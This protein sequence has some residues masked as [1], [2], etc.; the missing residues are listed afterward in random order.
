MSHSI[1]EQLFNIKAIQLNFKKPFSYASGLK[2]PI[3]CDNRLIWAYPKLRANIVNAL[4][5]MFEIKSISDKN[6]SIL[7]LATGGIPHGIL[8][9][10]RKNMPFGYIRSSAKVHG[11]NNLIE[12]NIKSG[13]TVLLIEDLVNQASSL[14]KV[15][16]HLDEQKIKYANCFCIVN[17][18][19][20][21]SKIVE[22]KYSININSLITF[23]NIISFMKESD[24]YQSKEIDRLLSW[25]ESPKLY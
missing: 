8:L 18:Q 4:S 20:K 11:K 2:G 12:G 13:D 6:M 10:E 5:N 25:K 21:N 1:L 22:D 15:L 14:E 19:T 16:V 24:L 7:G 9:A 3:Y 17:Y 23:D